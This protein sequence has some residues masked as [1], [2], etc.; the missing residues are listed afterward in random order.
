MNRTASSV[1]RSMAQR[2]RARRLTPDARRAQILD[3]AIKVFARR[4]LSSATHADVAVEAEVAA[5][6]VFFY[7]PTR[8]ELERAVLDVVARF[9]IDEVVVSNDTRDEAAPLLLEKIMLAF[10]ASIESHPHHS[11]VWLEWSTAIRDDLWPLY[12]EFQERVLQAVRNTIGRG[13]RKGELPA[14]LHTADAARVLVGLG[15]MI[16]LM[17][18]AGSPQREVEHI[19]ASLV[20]GYVAREPSTK[21][22]ARRR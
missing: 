16:A 2:P 15:H 19:I 22:R 3:C 6:T 8:T 20:Q 12:L 1:T 10:A 18:F 4:G 14:H 5:A 9:L 17:K 7:F 21:P 11:R 13:K